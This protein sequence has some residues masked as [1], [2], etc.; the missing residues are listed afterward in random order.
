MATAKKKMSLAF[1]WADEQIYL[2]D[3]RNKYSQKMVEWANEFYGRY[4]FEIEGY[5]KMPLTR[6][7]LE[8]FCLVKERGVIAD[9]NAV[10][11]EAEQ[12]E[13]SELLSKQI[14]LSIAISNIGDEINHAALDTTLSTTDKKKK[15]DELKAEKEQLELQ[16]KINSERKILLNSKKGVDYES[17]FR[18]QLG[19]RITLLNLNSNILPI[20]FCKI[21]KKQ[22]TASSQRVLNT[23]SQT[24][25]QTS[26]RMFLWLTKP[27]FWW[28]RDFIAIDA[29]AG[30]HSLSHEIVH[31]A[32]RSHFVN[33]DEVKR[34]AI[35][36]Y[37]WKPLKYHPADIAGMIRASIYNE[38]DFQ[39]K[40]GR[41][42]PMYYDG[43]KNY[44]LNYNV[45]DTALPS[46]IILMDEDVGNF[47]KAFFVK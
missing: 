13:L 21:P 20:V 12:R 47:E 28:F 35:L 7:L 11:F 42:I 8:N 1:F 38:F 6:P 27:Y 31:A 10:L 33:D 5:P 22:K 29:E 26:I 46:E 2:N 36:Y 32:G 23:L 4:G 14:D 37:G 25:G 9:L 19:L 44:I 24:Y 3:F 17:E 34:N 15:A 45:E 40:F 39:E 30:P 16:Y 43:P 41:Q 18:R